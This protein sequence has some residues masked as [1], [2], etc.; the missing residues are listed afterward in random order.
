MYTQPAGKTPPPIPDRLQFCKALKN[1]GNQVKGVA[2]SVVCMFLFS[3]TVQPNG[4]TTFISCVQI[5]Y[6]HFHTSFS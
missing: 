2:I 6:T 3:Q 5:N 1:T 4:G